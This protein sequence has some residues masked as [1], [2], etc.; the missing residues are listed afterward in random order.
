MPRIVDKAERQQQLMHAALAVFGERGF[1]RA[2]MQDVADRAGVSKGSL[3]AYFDSKEQL[4]LATVELLLTP[5]FEASMDVFEQSKGPIRDRVEAFARSLCDGLEAWTELCFTTLQV[6]AELGREEEQ[7]LRL[8][9]GDL[10][11]RSADRLQ[12]AFDAA[13]ARGEA[14]P[15]PT[16]A[17][18]LALMAALDGSLLQAILIPDDFRDALRTEYIFRWCAAVVPLPGGDTQ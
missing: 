10:Y 2:T 16:R 7:P 13:V 8:L 4:L 14:P 15:F 17:A 18:A 3:Y 1:H 5:L 11:R 12:G 6:W 9:M